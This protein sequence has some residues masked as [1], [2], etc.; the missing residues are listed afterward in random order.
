LSTIV[1][2]KT[3]IA[4]CSVEMLLDRMGDNDE[5]QVAPRDVRAGFTLTA[6]ESTLGPG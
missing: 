6:R 4:R 5:S 1:P 3:Q 2:D